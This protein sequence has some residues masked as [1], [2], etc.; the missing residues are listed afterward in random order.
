MSR[1]DEAPIRF[2]LNGRRYELSRAQVEARLADAAPEAIHK[3]AVR[4]NNIWFPSVQ[5]FE[6]AV[7]VP[8]SK[9]ISHTA[10]RHLAALGFELRG[11]SEPRG[12]GHRHCL[13][14]R[15]RNAWPRGANDVCQPRRRVAHRGQRPGRSRPG[16][17]T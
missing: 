5:A 13:H 7:G 14:P 2:T 8:R 4:V 3:H 9:F 10:R 16:V 1:L 6:A 12:V 17:G 15:R 11:E